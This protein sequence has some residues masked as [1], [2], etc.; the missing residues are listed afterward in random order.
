MQLQKY[1]LI[2]LG[3]ALFGSAGSLVIYDIYLSEQLRRLLNRNA[4]SETGALAAAPALSDPSA[5]TPPRGS[6]H[7]QRCRC[8]WRSVSS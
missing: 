3:I 1:I 8:C 4:T 5:G 2:L 7:L 6:R